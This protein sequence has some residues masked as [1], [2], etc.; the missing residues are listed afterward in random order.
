MA[1]LIAILGGIAIATMPVDIFPYIDI[2]VVS[3]VWQ[4]NGL[5]P[6]EMESRIVTNFE[7]SLTANV[8]DIE[9]IESQS[10]QSV[11]VVRVL[12]PPER[13]GGPRAVADRDAVPGPGPQH[14]ARDVP[15]TGPEVRRGERADSAA[16][17]EQ[18]DAQGA[19]NLRPREQL[20]PHAARHRAGRDGLVSVRRQEPPDHGGPEPRRAVREAA[21]ADRRLERAESPEPDRAG[22][23]G[24][25][26][27][28]RISGPAEQQP[29]ESST[30]ST[31]CRSRRSTAR[32]S[33]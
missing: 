2:P 5:S 4:Y 16:R 28:H 32:R 30:S 21:V 23:H 13:A 12:L 17:V 3:V 19:G 33:T 27:R 8:V 10:H 24:E 14:A 7:R 25:I 20:H 18:P 15:A 26:R 29:A 31:T 22:R 11:A 9:H 1:L 6:E